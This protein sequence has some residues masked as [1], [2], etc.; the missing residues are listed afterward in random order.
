VAALDQF[1][2]Q[3]SLSGKSASKKSGGELRGEWTGDTGE[4]VLR[5]RGTSIL[6]LDRG[7]PSRLDAEGRPMYM[8]V[9]EW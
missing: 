9:Q 7:T 1:E 8:N 2:K 5:K 6:C 4:V 3:P